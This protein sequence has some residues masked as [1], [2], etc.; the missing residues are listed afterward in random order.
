[1]PLDVNPGMSGFVRLKWRSTDTKDA[2]Q[3]TKW[4][5]VDESTDFIKQFRLSDLAANTKY[6]VIAEAKGEEESGFESI[7]GTFLTAPK[8]TDREKVKFI[9]STCQAIRS[10][11]SG[12]DGHRAYQQMASLKPHF[13]VHTGD[14]IYYDKV[15]F[16]KSKAQARAKWNL[17][18]AYKHN[19]QFHRN[20]SSYFMKEDHDTLKNDC[21]PGQSY[22]KLTF[23]QGLSIFREQV[24]MGKST[25]RTFRWGKDVQIWLTENRDFRSPN[26]IDDG[27]AKTI[28][29]T[30][31]KDW[32]MKTLKESDATFRFVISPGPIVGPDKRGKN[33]N[34][35][36]ATFAHEGKELRQF[37]APLKNTYVICGDRHW[38]YC[39]KDPDNGLLEMG[40]GPI[41][42]QHS[43][44]GDPGKDENLHR[45]FGARGGFLAVTVT[46]DAAV[47]Q[48][49]SSNEQPAG[50]K[51]KVVYTE[52]LP[53][54]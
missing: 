51:P 2:Y 11:D 20:V 42:D 39:S 26:N 49:Y 19:R 37:L 53:L 25:Y 24:P 5:K 32:L 18:F 14:I 46:G 48:W 17:M 50:S 12:T 27:P 45:Y 7:D 41:N 35:S 52:T 33:D 15:P 28:L 1:M 40:C 29:G 3:E 10:I 22:G 21:W 47:A 8:A 23:D 13:F 38:Q 44:G 16:S 54:K 6:T 36:N 4:V 30:A 9:V 31:Q 34:H 43:F